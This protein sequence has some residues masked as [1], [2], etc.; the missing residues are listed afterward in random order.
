MRT[1]SEKNR[2]TESK[3]FSALKALEKGHLVR[4]VCR[5]YGIAESTY[6]T[7][8]TKYGELELSDM[9]RLKGLERENRRLKKLYADLSL[10]NQILKEFIEKTL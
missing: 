4:E 5:E 10:D 3:I 1:I 6:F 7:W 9:Q 8:K 2:L